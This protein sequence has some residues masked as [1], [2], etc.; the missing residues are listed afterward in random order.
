MYLDL[1]LTLYKVVIKDAWIAHK[2]LH[3]TIN[4]DLIINTKLF[5]HKDLINL[6]VE[7]LGFWHP[8]LSH[9][10]LLP[11]LYYTKGLIMFNI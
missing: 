9:Q 6:V 1:D 11:S 5:L 3:C 7:V 4:L 2:P 8:Q 10:L